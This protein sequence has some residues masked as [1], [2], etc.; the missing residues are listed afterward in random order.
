MQPPSSSSTSRHCRLQPT[1]F[2]RASDLPLF[3]P[4]QIASCPSPCSTS[5][6]Q[7]SCTQT[8]PNLQASRL[9]TKVPISCPGH[10]THEANSH[11][12][13]SVSNTLCR[14]LGLP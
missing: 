14:I 2:T 7:A 8:R 6:H 4:F 11:S 12:S 13:V 5:S 10:K 9:H 3:H 1:T